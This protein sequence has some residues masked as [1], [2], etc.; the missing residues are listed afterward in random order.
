MKM[1]SYGNYLVGGCISRPA[2]M[3]VGLVFS[4]FHAMMLCDPHCDYLLGC[5]CRAHDPPRSCLMK[6]TISFFSTVPEPSLS[7]VE[8]TSSKASSENSS[9]DPRL[10]RVSCTNFLVSSLSR[11]PDLSTS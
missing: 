2:Q 3:M 4:V 8:K 11:A 1:Y 5:Q 10:P 7:K 9:P 6:T